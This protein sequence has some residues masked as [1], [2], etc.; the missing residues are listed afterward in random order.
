[1]AL[2]LFKTCLFLL[3]REETL[4]SQAQKENFRDKYVSD[5]LK[6]KLTLWLKMVIKKKKKRKKKKTVPLHYKRKRN[7]SK[8]S[9]KK[10]GKRL[11]TPD[12]L[13]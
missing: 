5:S 2:L 10:E 3:R 9:V 4:H 7:F 12:W 8:D 11:L 6:S 1:L 13:F